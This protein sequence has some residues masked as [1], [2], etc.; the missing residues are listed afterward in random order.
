MK[1]TEEFKKF[2]DAM[3]KLLSVPHSEIKRKLDAEKA[4]KRKRKAKKASGVSS[5]GKPSST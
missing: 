1:K 2:D 3:G 5:Q 4:E